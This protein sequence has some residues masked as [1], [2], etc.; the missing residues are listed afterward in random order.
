MPNEPKNI[1]TTT[2]SFAA[3]SPELIENL[4]NCG[5]RVLI[6]PFARKLKEE[7]LIG[8]LSEY[9]PVG[10]LAGTEPIRRKVLENA[11]E[12]LRVISRVGA[13]WDNIDRDAAAEFGIR[14]YRTSGVLTQAVAELAVGLMLSALRAILPQD[15]M[16]RQGLWQKRMGSLLQGKI[17][18]IIGFGAI[19]QRVGELVQ[20]FGAEVVYYDSQPLSVSWAKRFSLSGLLEQADIISIHASGKE[21]ILGTAELNSI[22]KPG[23]ILINTARGELIDEQALCAAL[24]EGRIAYACL[25]VFNEEPYCGPL[26]SMDNLVLTPHIGSYAREARQL[27]EEA[28]TNNLLT[29]LQEAKAL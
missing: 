7:E 12:Y 10:L 29:G 3:E 2:S 9:H 6:N 27:M 21:R 8:L 16:L 11:K 13:G 26:C 14:V 19:G 4:K 24:T 25:D 28:A 22:G 15:R 23:V 20:A 1:L 18:G 5:L 17:V